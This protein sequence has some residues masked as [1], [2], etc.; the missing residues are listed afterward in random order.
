MS[1]KGKVKRCSKEIER[2]KK[3]L[4]ESK[5]LNRRLRQDFGSQIDKKTLENIVKFAV[6]QHIGNLRGG[7]AI[8]AMGVDKMNDLKLSINRNYEFGAAYIIKVTY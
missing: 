8:E 4:E 6:T 5:L 2:L 1:V 7:I 3:E